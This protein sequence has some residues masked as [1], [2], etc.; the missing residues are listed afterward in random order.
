MKLINEVVHNTFYVQKTT[1]QNEGRQM[2]HFMVNLLYK[3]CEY[4]IFQT[5]HLSCLQVILH[6]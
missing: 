2:S 5:L 1:H 6:V 4:G 3:C